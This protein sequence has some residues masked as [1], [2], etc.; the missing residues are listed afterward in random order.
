MRSQRWLGGARPSACLAARLRCVLYRDPEISV[1]TA[2]TTHATWI[3]ADHPRRTCTRMLGSDSRLITTMNLR[4]PARSPRPRLSCDRIPHAKRTNQYQ[5]LPRRARRRFRAHRK[6]AAGRPRGLLT[7]ARLSIPIRTS[8]L[9]DWKASLCPGIPESCRIVKSLRRQ[10]DTITVSHG[11][12]LNR[13][14]GTRRG[15]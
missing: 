7:R 5:S 2:D 15:D 9:H 12:P 3:T 8:R 11:R 13:A 6:C 14:S 10:R 1:V 4:A